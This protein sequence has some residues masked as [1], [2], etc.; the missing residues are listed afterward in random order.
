MAGGI[1][2]WGERG[3]SACATP[4][5]RRTVAHQTRRHLPRSRLRIE[6]L[7]VSSPGRSGLS[8]ILLRMAEAE[9]PFFSTTRWARLNSF[10]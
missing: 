3:E 1:R 5:E 9:H 7:G 8:G 10:G 2:G 4:G 6:R